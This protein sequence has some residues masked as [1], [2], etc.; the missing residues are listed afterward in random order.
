MAPS[1]LDYP[2]FV[3]RSHDLFLAGLQAE[4]KD[5]TP[6]TQL[7]PLVRPAGFTVDS[8]KVLIVAPHP[9]DECLMGGY[10]LR[11]KEEW[12]AKVYVVP[13][14][15]G[16]N[17]NRQ[18]ERRRELEAAVKVLGFELIEV[19]SRPAHDFS[20]L[21]GEDSLLQ[22]LHQ[23]KPEVVFSPHADDRHR[24]HLETHSVTH[25]ALEE[26]LAELSAQGK[27]QSVLWVQTEFWHPMLYPNLLVPYSVKQ[28]AQLGA[29][30]QEHL[31]EVARNPYHLRLPAWMMD[32]VRRGSEVVVADP[33]SVSTGSTAVSSVYGQIYFQKMISA[34][35]ST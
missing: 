6:Y 10:A 3:Q 16:S 13:F 33:L 21:N 17:V 22:L 15:Y 19:P 7:S 14:S 26:Y 35:S 9:D 8:P 2:Q 12:N 20:K 18:V 27:S 1:K 31:L 29:G 5:S 4:G 28:V 30:L 25:L 34:V 24:V 11:M 32:S 23:L